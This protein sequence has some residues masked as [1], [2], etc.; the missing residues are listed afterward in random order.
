MLSVNSGAVSLIVMKRGSSIAPMHRILRTLS[1]I[2]PGLFALSF[3]SP[4]SSLLPDC[5]VFR[6]LSSATARKFGLGPRVHTD[7]Q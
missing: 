4:S 3:S 2:H 1:S 5:Q 7:S 6:F